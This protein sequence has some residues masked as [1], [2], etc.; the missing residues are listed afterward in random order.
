M[1]IKNMLKLNKNRETKRS[2]KKLKK[3]FFSILKSFETYL[4]ILSL[5][6]FIWHFN[7]FKIIF[8]FN[9]GI[10]LLLFIVILFFI[11]LLWPELRENSKNFFTIISIIF[12]VF[13]FL[14]SSTQNKIDKINEVR[15]NKSST[16]GMIITTNSI[17][18]GRIFDILNNDNNNKDLAGQFKLNYFIIDV[19]FDNSAFVYKEFGEKRWQEIIKSATKM[20]AINS[21]ITIVQNLNIQMSNE[22]D[23]LIIARTQD[24]IRK[25]NKQII[26]ISEEISNA[27]CK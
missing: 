4:I 12:A 3:F 27:L 8:I 9:S 21:L 18:C 14:F 2:E 1:F 5:L 22:S 19:Y 10:L 25:Y 26:G 6:L 15:E 11:G 17:N 7:D 13:F 20:E 23:S 16:I 24:N